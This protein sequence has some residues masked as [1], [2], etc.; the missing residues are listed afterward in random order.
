MSET[1]YSI[2]GLSSQATLVEI[3]NAID[4]LRG[5]VLNCPISQ[6]QLDEIASTLLDEEKRAKY[7]LSLAAASATENRNKDATDDSD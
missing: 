5:D 4:K 7:D 3:S 2:I 1:Y 6:Q